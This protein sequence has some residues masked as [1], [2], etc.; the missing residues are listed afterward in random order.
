MNAEMRYEGLLTGAQHC[1][2]FFTM[3]D[4]DFVYLWHQNNGNPNCIGIF[5]LRGLTIDEVREAAEK[6]TKQEQK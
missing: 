2:G 6:Y 1:A 4:P 5:L 3:M